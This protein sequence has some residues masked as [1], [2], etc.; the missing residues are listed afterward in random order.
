MI[1]EK[2]VK[3]I[4]YYIAFLL[5]FLSVLVWYFYSKKHKATI[6]VSVN[7]KDTVHFNDSISKVNDI[8]FE[9][10]SSDVDYQII[11]FGGFQIIDNK[12]NDITNK[13]PP[14]LKEL[15]LL[16]W[17]YSLKNNK[18]ISPDKLIEIIWHFSSSLLRC[19][20]KTVLVF[21][22]MSVHRYTCFYD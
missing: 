6:I 3:Y 21:T 16:I 11:F 10:I 5:L 7:E 17:L 14:L 4:L 9:L 19:S 2:N 18:G 8:D 22:I 15:F 20:I 12:Q 13:F 1:W